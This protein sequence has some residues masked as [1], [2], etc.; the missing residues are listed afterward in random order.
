MGNCE[1]L[2]AAYP[3]QRVFSLKREE[4]IAIKGF[5][6]KTAEEML[7]GMKAT[8]ELFNALYG[9]GF[10]LLATPLDTEEEGSG[11]GPLS[12]KLIVFTGTMQTGSR[13]DMKK[14]AKALGAKIGESI[15]GK[16][17]L[18]VCG[19]KVGAA[20]LNKAET[21]GVRIVTEQEYLAMLPQFHK[22]R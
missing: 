12:G 15:T 8:A 3:L 7:V 11:E 1:K 14:Q 13:E 19:E 17:D 18:L 22:T 5:S 4:I 10:N 21:L 16:T 2:L 6:E 20:K 9:L